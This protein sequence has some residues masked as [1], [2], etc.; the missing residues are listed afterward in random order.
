M[1]EY[2][3]WVVLEVMSLCHQQYLQE[4]PSPVSLP[5]VASLRLLPNQRYFHTAEVQFNLNHLTTTVRQGIKIPTTSTIRRF[6]KRDI[7][8]GIISILMAL[9]SKT[10]N[11]S[12][13]AQR[14]KKT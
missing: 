14:L 11:G 9:N 2:H 6:G 7:L 12:P 5:P 13:N 4:A 3:F 1:V 10:M 8:L